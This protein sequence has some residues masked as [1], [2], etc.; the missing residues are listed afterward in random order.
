M[1]FPT[2]LYSNKPSD[3]GENLNVSSLQTT[4]RSGVLT[5]TNQFQ[6]NP[7]VYPQ[8]LGSVKDN[9]LK[10]NFSNKKFRKLK[11]KVCIYVLDLH[12]PTVTGLPVVYIYM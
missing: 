4:D 2:K 1:N 12:I 11:H 10:Y 7:G 6:H 9:I 5:S 3:F 8:N